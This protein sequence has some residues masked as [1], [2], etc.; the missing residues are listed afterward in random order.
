[1]EVFKGTS[2]VLEAAGPGASLRPRCSASRGPQAAARLITERHEGGALQDGG[3]EGGSACRDRRAAASHGTPGG[4]LGGPLAAL[5][6]RERVSRALRLGPPPPGTAPS[7][8]IAPAAPA[9]PTYQAPP[10]RALSRPSGHPPASRLLGESAKWRPPP[11]PGPLALP[12]N[13]VSGHSH[14]SLRLC[15]PGRVPLGLARSRAALTPCEALVSPE[16]SPAGFQA[17]SLPAPRKAG[18]STRGQG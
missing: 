8:R 17:H 7:A 6:Q 2:H 3:A 5:Q 10:A 4:A 16:V 12:Q 14:G 15:V 9:T 13:L 11:R 18:T 1:M